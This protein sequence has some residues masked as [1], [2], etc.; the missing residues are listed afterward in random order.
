MRRALTP[1][2][3]TPCNAVTSIEVEVGRPAPGRLTLSYVLTGDVSSLRLPPPASS[4]RKDELWKHTCFEAFILSPPSPA[5][6]ELNLAPSTEWAAYRFDSYREGMADVN[7]PDP[8][9]TIATAPGRLDLH[10]VVDLDLP[11]AGLWCLGLTAVIE[12]TSGRL[13]YWALI[14]P[15]GRP[16]FHNADCFTLELPGT[17]AG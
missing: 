11:P 10:A 14:H 16:E 3:A 17:L 5:Y 8:Q 7:I 4:V 15:A 2:A 1:H 9:I 6:R 13:S 12:E